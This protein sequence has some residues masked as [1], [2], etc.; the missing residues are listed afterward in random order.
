M[1]NFIIFF[2]NLTL[3]RNFFLYNSFSCETFSFKLNSFPVNMN[4]PHIIMFI[5]YFAKLFT[6]KDSNHIAK[7]KIKYQEIYIN[8]YTGFYRNT[9]VKL[10][11]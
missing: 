2:F 10:F 1:V 11:S 7:L 5:V 9:F 6:R 3:K 8:K 4:V